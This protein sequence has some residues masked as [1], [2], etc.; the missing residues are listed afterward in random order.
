MN[1]YSADV[2]L[3]VEVTREGG[4]LQCTVRP[5]CDAVGRLLP[6]GSGSAALAEVARQAVEL[7]RY[8]VVKNAETMTALRVHQLLSNG[9][10]SSG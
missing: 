6:A 4:S 9:W 8:A 2:A 5:R 10:P 1:R 3:T 7:R